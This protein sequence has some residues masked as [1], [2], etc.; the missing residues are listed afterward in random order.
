MQF[1]SSDKVLITDKR[2]LYNKKPG[3]SGWEIFLGDQ[4]Y[5]P[6]ILNYLAAAFQKNKPEKI[7][8]NINI[9]LDEFRTTI[10]NYAGYNGA[11]AGAISG[12][13]GI[14]VIPDHSNNMIKCQMS[15]MINQKEF[16]SEQ[17]ISYKMPLFAFTVFTDEETA[18]AIGKCID[19][20]IIKIYAQ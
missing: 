14:P 3:H 13:T 8:S 5:Q 17:Y 12:A 4:N 2:N 9:V 11:M 10:Y 15:G 1:N 20:L 19:S 18:S 6:N 7:S 16:N